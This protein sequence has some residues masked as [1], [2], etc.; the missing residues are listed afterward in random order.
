MIENTNMETT[1]KISIAEDFS[2]YPAGRYPEDGKFNGTAFRKEKLVPPLRENHYVEVS[3][4]GVVGCGSS[5]LEEAFGGL[6]REGFGK[7]F[8][9]SH[10]TITAEDKDMEDFVALS[11]EY[12]DNAHKQTPK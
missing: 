9:D 8:L 10:L 5:F 4:D 11:R 6:I 3:L 2:R 7:D 1:E 12:I